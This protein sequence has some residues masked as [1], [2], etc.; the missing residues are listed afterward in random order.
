MTG[1]ISLI[2]ILG[3]AVIVLALVGLGLIAFIFGMTQDSIEHIDE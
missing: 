3:L 2:V 1:L